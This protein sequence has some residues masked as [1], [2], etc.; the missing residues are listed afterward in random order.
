MD[1]IFAFFAINVQSAKIRSHGEYVFY[2]YVEY[3][4]VTINI[5]CKSAKIRSARILILA[6]KRKKD[7]REK[8]CY[9]V[10]KYNS[11]PRYGQMNNNNTAMGRMGADPCTDM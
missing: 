8:R 1:L 3:V 7:P 10:E 9:T 2:S 5:M 6:K 4:N 11:K